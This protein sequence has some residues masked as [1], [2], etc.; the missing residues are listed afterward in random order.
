M[1][2][3]NDN[4]INIGNKNKINNSIIGNSIDCNYRPGNIKEKSS[5]YS[6]LFWK[7]LIPIMVAVITAIIIWKLG[8]N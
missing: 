8:L 7:I 5:W 1:K 6:Q 3:K 2:M 4:N